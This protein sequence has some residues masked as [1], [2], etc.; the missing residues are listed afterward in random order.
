MASARPHDVARLSRCIGAAALLVAAMGTP[1]TAQQSA[2]SSTAPAG[3]GAPAHAAAH[4]IGQSPPPAA[5]ASLGRRGNL[6]APG[7]RVV[8]TVPQGPPMSTRDRLFQLMRAAT[9][10]PSARPRPPSLAGPATPLRNAIGIRIDSPAVA[11]RATIAHWGQQPA[12]VATIGTTPTAAPAS[13]A[14]HPGA[15]TSTPAARGTLNGTALVRIGAGA[16]VIGGPAKAVTGI[17]GTTL[18]R[19]HQ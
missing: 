15:M 6:S 3:A 14:W 12:H 8:P 10:K 4:D 2:G 9:P 1:G 5:D 19:K 18:R 7:V 16:P 13:N 11:R 17:N